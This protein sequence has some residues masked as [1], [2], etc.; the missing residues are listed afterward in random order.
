MVNAWKIRIGEPATTA[1]SHGRRP[2]M[3]MVA[4]TV[5][6]QASASPNAE[7]LKNMITSA[8][9]GIRTSLDSAV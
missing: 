1:A 4:H 3:R 6:I 8:T 5:A 9:T 7:M 2:D